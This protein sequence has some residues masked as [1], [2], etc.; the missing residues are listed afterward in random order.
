MQT[1][2]WPCFYSLGPSAATKKPLPTISISASAARLALVLVYESVTVMLSCALQLFSSQV[3][4]VDEFTGR[5]VDGRSWSDGLQQAT[6][7]G[8]L[9]FRPW[10]S[11]ECFMVKRCDIRV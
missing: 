7:T 8:V 3:V 10:Q 9:G 2:Q 6:M 5:P 11:S 4:V 1:C